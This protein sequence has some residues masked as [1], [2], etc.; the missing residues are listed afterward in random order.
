MKK[1]HEGSAR[2]GIVAILTIAL[3]GL[4][5]LSEAPVVAS[6]TTPQLDCKGGT[7]P[8]ASVALANGNNKK[9]TLPHVTVTTTSS[10]PLIVAIITANSVVTIA[11]GDVN[12][13]GTTM[14]AECAASGSTD[15]VAVYYLAVS[16]TSTLVESGVTTSSGGP[17]KFA[18][19]IAFGVSGYASSNTFDGPCGTTGGGATNPSLSISGLLYGN[20][21]VVG[22]V[23][24]S[25]TSI[26]LTPSSGTSITS[27]SPSTG[28]TASASYIY[29]TGIGSYTVSWTATGESSWQEAVFAI[30]DSTPTSVPLFPEGIIPLV[31][32][33]P[34]LYLML[35]RRGRKAP[36][37]VSI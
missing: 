21:M 36:K 34:I 29:G 27:V 8:S 35:V 18:T 11:A 23:G 33:I 37:G 5:L 12:A 26:T 7:C 24:V 22:G 17:G 3:V 28:Y 14:S 30:A 31:F 9:T 19:I 6:A 4:T 13:S 16:G 15:I 25:G 2:V 10:T 1:N 20:D 32:A